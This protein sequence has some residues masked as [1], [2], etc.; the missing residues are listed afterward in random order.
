M[1]D[2]RVSAEKHNRIFGPPTVKGDRPGRRRFYICPFC[3]DEHQRGNVPDNCKVIPRVQ[4]HLAAPQ[5]APSFYEHKT[6]VLSDAEVITSRT[7]QRE[8]MK[9]NDLIQWEEGF[10]HRNEWVEEHETK[11]EI[12]QTIKMAMERDP[13][14]LTP[15]EKGEVEDLAKDGSEG[16]EI[17]TKDIEIIK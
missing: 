6:G 14:S 7:A 5:L 13:L 9:K 12:V 16:T 2:H 4:Q 1:P 8:Y 17:D 10:D 11:R 15:E 3:G